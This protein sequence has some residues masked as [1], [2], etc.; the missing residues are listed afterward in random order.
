MTEP[1]GQP[2][3]RRTAAEGRA[4]PGPDENLARAF[5]LL[6]SARIAEASSREFFWYSTVWFI[7]Y[8]GCV[9]ALLCAGTGDEDAPI[10]H[11]AWFYLAVSLLFVVVGLLGALA[12]QR[13]A[14]AMFDEA[15]RYTAS[16]VERG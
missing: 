6:Q 16:G 13:R 8:G 3:G 2:A 15:H 10:V 12:A 7:V 11:F 1:N 9:L 4:V 5:F 14:R